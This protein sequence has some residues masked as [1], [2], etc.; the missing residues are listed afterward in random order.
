MFSY[1]KT[2]FFNNSSLVYYVASN[3]YF[4]AKV[5]RNSILHY[6]IQKAN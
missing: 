1:S 5:H 6:N 4:H 3:K 2:V